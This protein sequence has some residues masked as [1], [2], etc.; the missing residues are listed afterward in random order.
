MCIFISREWHNSAVRKHRRQAFDRG[1]R[2]EASW[3][4]LQRETFDV[5]YLTTTAVQLIDAPI[6]R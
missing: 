3:L 5:L 6:A 4:R 2:E 1:F